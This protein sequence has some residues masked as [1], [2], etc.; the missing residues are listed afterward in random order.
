MHWALV[1][2]FIFGCVQKAARQ[3]PITG[4]L[5]ELDFVAAVP[6]AFLQTESV[7]CGKFPKQLHFN[8]WSK[9]NLSELPSF[10]SI[11]Q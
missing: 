6:V 8:V 2:L 4:P 11:R 10:E 1:V 3:Q 5:T 7:I 9:P